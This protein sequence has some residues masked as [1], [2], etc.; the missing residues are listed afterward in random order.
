MIQPV[1]P[2]QGQWQP[3]DQRSQSVFTFSRSKPLIINAPIFYYYLFVFT[4]YIECYLNFQTS[5]SNAL[6]L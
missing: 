6:L 2:A 5:I 1:T 4:F 3:D